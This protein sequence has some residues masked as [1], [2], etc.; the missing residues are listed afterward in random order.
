MSTAHQSPAPDDAIRETIATGCRILAQHG[1]AH[2]ILGHVSARIDGT[3]DMWI[4]CRSAD[5]RGVRY[6]SADA[7]Q[8]VDLDGR[9]PVEAGYQLPMELPIHGRILAARPEVAAVVHAHPTYAVLCGLADVPLLPIYGAFD[10]TMVELTS[11]GIPTYPRSRLINDD[12][13]AAELIA[14]MD[15]RDACLMRGHGVTV[16]GRS[17]EEAVLRAVRLERLAW[18]TWQLAAAGRT[19]SAISDEDLA[20]FSSDPALGIPRATEW[21]WRYYVAHEA[22]EAEDRAGGAQAG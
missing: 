11:R 19:P 22:H 6:T 12:H 14:A 21:A 15:G 5:E 20:F 10:T 4:R 18:F 9:G 16:V 8:R 17:V 3:T 1:L 2:E 13:S 7:V